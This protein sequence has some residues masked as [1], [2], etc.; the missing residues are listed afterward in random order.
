VLPHTA[1]V[2]GGRLFSDHRVTH[3]FH[4]A[5]YA[6]EGLSHFIRRFNYVNNVIGSVTLINE[7]IRH[8]IEC[9]VFTSS[10]AVYGSI[11]P[12]MRE[13]DQP[14]PEDPYGV[15][16]LAVELDLIAANRMFGLDYVILRP[17]NV[18][19]EFQNL[20]DPYR[21][22]IGIFMNQVMQARPMT[23]F[24]DGSQQR[25]FSYVGDIVPAVA[26]SP[27]IREARNGV[28][29]I[30]AETPY[31]VNE[32]ARTVALAMGSPNHPVEYLPARNEVYAAY[33]DHTRVTRVFGGVPQTS[34]DQGVRRMAEWAQE[35]G[36]RAGKP[37]EAIELTMG[38]PAKWRELAGRTA[39][40]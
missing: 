28:F 22:V 20:G 31:S 6:A 4:L 26:A 19:G 32:L 40:A 16:K 9:F 35:A 14:L 39:H 38:L 37:F 36:S 8:K 23:I 5:A 27:W 18:Y 25:A 21:N 24:G 7:A 11:P 17:H 15:A 30:G 12:P 33:S 3:V 2:A 34:L 13:T 1:P 10:I 29:N